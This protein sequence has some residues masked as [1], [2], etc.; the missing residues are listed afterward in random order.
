M[1][2]ITP[3]K[4]TKADGAGFPVSLPGFP[5]SVRGGI[6]MKKALA[7]MAALWMLAAAAAACESYDTIPDGLFDAAEFVENVNGYGSCSLVAGQERCCLTSG[8]QGTRNWTQANLVTDLDAFSVSGSF[9]IN[10][11]VYPAVTG[12]NWVSWAGLVNWSAPG[13]RINYTD[14]QA[15][16]KVSLLSGATNLYCMGSDVIAGTNG[17]YKQSG[18]ANSEVWISFV[19]AWGGAVDVELTNSTGAHFHIGSCSIPEEAF[20]TPAVAI[21]PTNTINTNTPCVTFAGVKIDHNA[22]FSPQ[23]YVHSVSGDEENCTIIE[24]S[25]V[26]GSGA[27]CTALPATS[28]GNGLASALSYPACG[29]TPAGYESQYTVTATCPDGRVGTEYEIIDNSDPD[30]LLPILVFKDGDAT[31]GTCN[32]EFQFT[33]QFGNPYD[34]RIAFTIT[35]G[36]NQMISLSDYNGYGNVTFADCATPFTVRANNGGIRLQDP[37][38][39]TL[40]TPQ[41]IIYIRLLTNFDSQNVAVNVTGFGSH[42]NAD[43][44]L[45]LYACDVGACNAAGIGSQ[46]CWN[47]LSPALDAG[48]DAHG[49]QTFTRPVICAVA[50]SGLDAGYGWKALVQGVQNYSI[51]VDMGLSAPVSQY[52][53]KFTDYQNA[54][55]I[56]GIT[57]YFKDAAGSIGGPFTSA[58]D[59]SVYFSSDSPSNTFRVTWDAKS[60]YAAGSF[61]GPF[62]ANTGTCPAM[63]LRRNASAVKMCLLDGNISVKGIVKSGIGATFNCD[64]AATSIVTDSQGFAFAVPCGAVCGVSPK[65]DAYTVS[66]ATIEVNVNTTWDIE[67]LVSS[68]V[69]R[70]DTKDVSFYAYEKL[71]DGSVSKVS[72]AS[73]AFVL[74][75]KTYRCTGDDTG[76]CTIYDV[77]A[78]YAGTV[79][80]DADGYEEGIASVGSGTYYAPVELHSGSAG[81]CYV[82]GAVTAVNGTVS[83]SV[84][85]AVQYLDAGGSLKYSALTQSYEFKADCGTE[86]SVQ[87]QYLSRTFG[88]KVRLPDKA[89]E[90]LDLP[91]TFSLTES[92]HADD[93]IA[94]F[95]NFGDLIKVI[96]FMLIVG[97]FFKAADSWGGH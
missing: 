46:S 14:S 93:L 58:A 6:Q 91:I 45:R 41:G 39:G 90:R 15:W 4:G 79:Y 23:Y 52:C 54:S 36:S 56:A 95:W 73:F 81:E 87:A 61:E 86:G 92:D 9:A 10:M 76:R 49:S 77:P 1:T 75:G 19:K 11:S 26:A 84:V 65:S 66:D 7:A 74:A 25:C 2:L 89:G 72:R 24:D 80:A 94:W 96:V 69:G 40:F 27:T 30:P 60:P 17:T 28:D 57:A 22:T 67:F 62:P 16:A 53:A 13:S 50:V 48:M 21:T 12:G 3:Q 20:V 37:N 51:V 71:D 34:A 88:Q 82:S 63:Q 59:G 32:Q 35:Q 18:S 43:T 64:G 29:R 78:G 55:A 42:T 33:D 5:G 97:I 44:T 31:P 85:G 70:T 68:D 47:V 83:R 8:S 38:A